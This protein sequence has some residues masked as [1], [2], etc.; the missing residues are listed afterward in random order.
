[1]ADS[2]LLLKFSTAVFLVV[3]WISVGT[4]CGQ[5][6]TLTFE[7]LP[8][9][10]GGFY[11]GDPSGGFSAYRDNFTVRDTTDNGAGTIITQ[12]TWNH[13]GV[14]FNNTYSVFPFFESWSGFSWSNVVETT[15]PGFENQ[16]ASFAGGGSN[17]AGV[18]NA[19]E[20]YIVGFG[21]QSYFNLPEQITLESVD[22]TNTTYAGL[23]MRDGD[24]F[25]KAFG[26]ESGND[27]DF[28]SIE[29]TGYDA[30]DLGGAEI[31][32]VEFFLSDFRFS[33][34]N[35]DYIVDQ[36]THLDL[37]ALG[38][39][40]SI[41]ISFTTTDV[42][43]FGPNTPSYV[44]LDNLTYSVTAVPEPSNLGILFSLLF[45]LALRR[46]KRIRS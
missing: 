25:A 46:E 4:T 23:S 26:G 8:V 37:S 41:G 17:G 13:G 45:P 34:N 12:Q 3:H 15:T 2:N 11:N 10:S 29:F 22:V 32:S 39:A 19:G 27:P 5:T 42:G 20:N 38:S 21:N 16:Y 40:R 14:D 24:A 43:M 6:T 28:F 36:W 18:A 9:P 31:G 30:V 44:A 35:L 1:M 7:S 33:D